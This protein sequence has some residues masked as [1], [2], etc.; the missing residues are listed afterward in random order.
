MTGVSFGD[1]MEFMRDP[2]GGRGMLVGDSPTKREWISFDEGSKKY[3]KCVTYFSGPL[4]EMNQKIRNE[5]S[6]KRFGDGQI[7]ASIPETEYYRSIVPAQQNGDEK[8]IKKFL[9][10]SESKKFRTF[11]GEL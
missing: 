11:D 9:N 4:F 2:F 8:W 1:Y 10:R 5:N 7:V 3:I 6:G